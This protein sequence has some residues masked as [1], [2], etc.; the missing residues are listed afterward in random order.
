MIH[1]GLSTKDKLM[2]DL[3]NKCY[4]CVKKPDDL[5]SLLS[6]CKLKHEIKR[7]SSSNRINVFNCDLSRFEMQ[8]DFAIKAN[9]SLLN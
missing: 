3:A 6:K 2:S 8:H 9:M 7:F 1:T 4:F 5:S